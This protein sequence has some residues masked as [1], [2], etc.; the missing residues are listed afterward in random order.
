MF[1]PSQTTS[2]VAAE[3]GQG[4]RASPFLSSRASPMKSTAAQVSARWRTVNE[5]SRARLK[6]CTRRQAASGEHSSDEFSFNGV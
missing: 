4:N 5:Q 1:V 2:A 6:T 3:Q